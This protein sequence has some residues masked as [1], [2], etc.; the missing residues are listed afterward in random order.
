[1]KIIYHCF[2]GTHSS[3]TAAA[4]HLG[5]LPGD[6]IP[7]ARRFMELPYY[8]KRDGWDRGEIVFMGTDKNGHEIYAVGRGSASALLTNLIDNLALLLEIP[9]GSYRLVDMM[10]QVNL[11]MKLGGFMSRRLGMVRLG[12]PIVVAG[13]RLAFPAIKDLVN[14]VKG[15]VSQAA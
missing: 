12:R 9:A 11:P 15:E 5:W 1:M 13:T 2:G 6:K 4:I 10:K 14:K 8:D 3:I 7:P